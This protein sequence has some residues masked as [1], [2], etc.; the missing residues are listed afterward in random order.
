MGKNIK[1]RNV[2]VFYPIFQVF[3]EDTTTQKPTEAPIALPQTQNLSKD[4]DVGQSSE[5]LNEVPKTLPLTSVTGSPKSRP[6]APPKPTTQKATEAPISLLQTQNLPK[7]TD[8]SK[9][10][11]IQNKV[12][13]TLPLAPTTPSPKPLLINLKVL[14]SSVINMEDSQIVALELDQSSAS[15]MLQPKIDSAKPLKG[16]L[17]APTDFKSEI[18]DPSTSDG[19]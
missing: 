19:N 7:E 13:K 9:P 8:V 6:T 4:T 12:P 2:F 11:E 3:K 10:S 5:I 17:R 14:I 1:I 18:E 15:K 16:I